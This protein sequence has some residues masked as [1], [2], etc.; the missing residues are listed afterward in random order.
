LPKE[1]VPSFDTKYHGKVLL[2]R[3][4]RKLKSS[5]PER[6]FLI[7]NQTIIKDILKNPSQIR[8]SLSFNDDYL[9]YKS[10]RDITLNIRDE[11]MKKIYPRLNYLVVV[12][13]TK[14]R[15]IKTIFP[16]TRIKRGEKIWPK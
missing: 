2:Y 16:A 9:Y 10:V 15:R 6:Q 11:D 7:L 14:S 3:K 13:C 5:Y 4:T 8:R 12:I 1:K